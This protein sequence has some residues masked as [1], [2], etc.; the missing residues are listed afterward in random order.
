MTPPSPS[1]SDGR[2]KILVRDM[3]KLRSEVNEL[4]D[5]ESW[6]LRVVL[7]LLLVALFLRSS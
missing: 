6:K 3:L 2:M 1:P 7:T 4:G 5:D